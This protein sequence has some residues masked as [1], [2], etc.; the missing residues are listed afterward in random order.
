ML[1]R[2]RERNRY[3]DDQDVARDPWRGIFL[4]LRRAILSGEYSPGERLV[5]QQLAD[6]FGTSRGPVRTAL[7]RLERTGLVISIDRRGTFVRSMSA[8]EVEEAFSLMS[9]LMEFAV[10]RAVERMTPADREWLEGLKER[11]ATIIDPIE[12][13]ELQTAYGRRVFEIAQHSRALEIYDS[14]AAQTS[15]QALFATALEHMDGWRTDPRLDVAANCDALLRGD[16]EEAVRL[17]NLL[18]DAIYGY[19]K[20]HGSDAVAVDPA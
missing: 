9:V 10:R 17:G 2:P 6:R 3:V 8:T 18:L 11:A 4:A 14:M 1:N 20:K 16:A 15:A 19:W 5:E 7:Q 12:E 13:L